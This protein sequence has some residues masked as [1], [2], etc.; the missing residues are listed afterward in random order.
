MSLVFHLE[1]TRLCVLGCDGYLSLFSPDPWGPQCCCTTQLPPNTPGLTD[2][3][4]L[5]WLPVWSLPGPGAGLG[6]HSHPE[7]REAARP[8]CV[9]LIR[10]GIREGEK[11]G[12]CLCGPSIP[13][14]R[15]VD[16]SGAAVVGW[17]GHGN[18]ERLRSWARLAEPGDR[19]ELEIQ[20]DALEPGQKVVVVDDLLATGGTM[21]AA[22][23]LLGQLQAQVLECVSLVELTSLKGREKLGA[24]PFFSLL[25]Y[26]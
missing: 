26:E 17:S 22:C 12:G 20:R 18:S 15:V 9:C 3:P 5:P 24:V 25:Q 2:R 16:S 11:A 10:T 21:R 1:A 7:A 13:K 14:R 4:R 8:H 6:L 23:E 19:A